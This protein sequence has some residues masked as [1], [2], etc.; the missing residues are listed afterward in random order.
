M[1]H[2]RGACKFTPALEKQFPMFKKTKFMDEVTC[3]T[4]NVDINII[5]K[6]KYD[7]TQHVKSK[8]HQTNISSALSER[9][10]DCVFEQQQQKETE[11]IA[12]VE[13][14]LSFHIVKH[15]MS[16]KSADCTHSLNSKLFKDSKVV[17][18][19]ALARTKTEAIINNVLAPHT[20]EVSLY[21]YIILNIVIIR[22]VLLFF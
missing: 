16:Y 8:K 19:I 22:F 17:S 15:H 20:I 5:N 13:A 12:A 3:T 9:K 2:K 10:I 18:K 6:G 7:L 11:E 4:C 1:N 14:T 21:M